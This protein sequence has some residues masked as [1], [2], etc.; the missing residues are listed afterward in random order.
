MRVIVWPL[1]VTA[2]FPVAACGEAPAAKARERGKDAEPLLAGAGRSAAKA[3]TADSSAR[4][5]SKRKTEF[6]VRLMVL[7]FR[8]GRTGGVA[9]KAG[10]R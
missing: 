3:F 5:R 2:T 1:I 8:Y 10:S 7:R 4:I 9:R 6:I